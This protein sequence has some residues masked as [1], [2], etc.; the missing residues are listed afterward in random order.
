LA[1]KKK[2]EQRRGNYGSTEIGKGRNTISKLL[3]LVW[4]KKG[5]GISSGERVKERREGGIKIKGG[6]EGKIGVGN[7]KKEV[8]MSHHLSTRG[9][10]GR[11]ED[12]VDSRTVQKN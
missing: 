8:R 2:R 1:I 12:R 5:G 9:G 11:Q 6:G 10:G 7:K 3:S 4:R